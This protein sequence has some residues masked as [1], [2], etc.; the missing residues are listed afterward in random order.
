MTIDQILSAL[1]ITKSEY[2]FCLSVA[3]GMEHEIHLK[4]PPNSC[5]INNFI[6]IVFLA[7]QA[8]MDI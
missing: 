4:R 1:E 3:A 2:Y 7:W 6:P 5:F 8:N